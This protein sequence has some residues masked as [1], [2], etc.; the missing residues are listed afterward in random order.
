M[1]LDAY[2]GKCAVTACDIEDL[3]EAA[4]IVPYRGPQTNHVQN[5]ILLRSDIH[6][7]FDCGLIA[8]DPTTGEI[9]LSPR[10]MHSGY[11]RLA[12]RKIRQPKDHHR[13]PSKEALLEHRQRCS[14]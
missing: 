8:V 6:T 10:I 13:A 1:L 3:L 5:G 11:R 14:L 12:G 9:I 7:L 2:D 4:H